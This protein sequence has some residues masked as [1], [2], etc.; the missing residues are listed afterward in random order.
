MQW[1]TYDITFRAPRFDAS[2]R[3]TRDAMI[4]VVHNGVM[5]HENVAIPRPTAANI[6]GDIRE[7]QGLH[8]QDH[9]NPVQFRNI[10]AVE[11]SE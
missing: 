3:K 2:G 10:W 9:G 5:I 6:G 8:L 4:T 7:P 1:Q 11:L